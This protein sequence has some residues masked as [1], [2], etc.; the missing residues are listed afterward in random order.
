MNDPPGG[1]RGPVKGRAVIRGD[2]VED[3]VLEWLR[4]PT[5]VLG[6]GNRLLGDDAAGSLVCERAGRAEAVDCGDAPERYLGLAGAEWV[7][8][9]LMVDAMDFG[10]EAGEAAFCAAGDLRE[11]FGTTHN[12]GLALLAR[13]IEEEYGKAVAVLGIQPS[14]T[15]FGAALHPA[16]RATVDRVVA[17]LRRGVGERRAREM[18]AAWTQS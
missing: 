11:R 1:S 9:V 10:G 17:W 14:D 2:Q 4:A 15:G 7:E 8:R 5:L 3:A 18:E 16:V 12:S 13:F 6:V